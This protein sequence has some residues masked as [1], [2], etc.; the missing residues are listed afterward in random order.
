LFSGQPYSFLP[1]GPSPVPQPE[2]LSKGEVFHAQIGD[3]VLLPCKVKNLGPMILLWK[4]GTRVLTA[5]EMMIRRA[6][7]IFLKGTDLQ[8]QNV[9]PEDGGIYSCEIEADSEYPIVVT[10]TLEVL[11]K[12]IDDDEGRSKVEALLSQLSLALKKPKRTF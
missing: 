1:I 6:D 9:T 8:V 3:T 11:G 5:G 4:K 10:H 2:V 7:R 12:L